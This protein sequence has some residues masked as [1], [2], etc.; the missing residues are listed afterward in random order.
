VVLSLVHIV[1]SRPLG[2]HGETCDAS[3]IYL[4]PQLPSGDLTV[5]KRY[6]G[7][8]LSY[9]TK[10]HPGC[11]STIFILSYFPHPFDNKHFKYVL[12]KQLKELSDGGP[13]VKFC[14]LSGPSDLEKALRNILL[15]T[16]VLCSVADQI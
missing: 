9:F 2:G 13:A 14:Y 5:N 3:A 4:A 15:V 7:E 6:L 11:V 1:S 12:D 16:P 10:Q 8:G